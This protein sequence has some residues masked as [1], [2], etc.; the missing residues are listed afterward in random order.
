MKKLLVI[1][2]CMLLLLPTIALAQVD[3]SGLSFD[4]LVAL[5]ERIDFALWASEEWQAV[6]VPPG[7]YQVG[8]DIPP[9]HWTITAADGQYVSIEWGS[10]LDV[11]KT[12]IDF[13][14][15]VWVYDSVYS[16]TYRYYE[17]GDTTQV[18]YE[19]S[20]GIYVI[21]DDGNAVFSPYTGK[22]PLGF[23]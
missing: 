6:T 23:R 2:L 12:A 9:G 15:K 16:K 11:S 8:K 22:P 5:R 13:M 10:D 20:A 14:S 7:V 17:S 21:I 3:I 1:F 4:E 18:D 19:L